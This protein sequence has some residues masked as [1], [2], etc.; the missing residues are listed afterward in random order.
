MTK[1]I[2]NSLKRKVSIAG[3]FYIEDIHSIIEA[4]ASSK[5]EIPLK[6]FKDIVE[7]YY[8]VLASRTVSNFYTFNLPERLGFIRV[9]AMEPYMKFDGKGRVSSTNYPIDMERYHQHPGGNKFRRYYKMMVDRVYKFVV[10]KGRFKNGYRYTFRASPHIRKQ[11]RDL[12]ED[13]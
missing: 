9:R 2:L 7:D 6:E 1:G 5:F 13:N 11:I 12:Y 3:T 8:D 4:K 10:Y